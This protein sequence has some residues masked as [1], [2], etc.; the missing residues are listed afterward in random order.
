MFTYS[1]FLL[2]IWFNSSIYCKEVGVK[3][4]TM[5]MDLFVSSFS[6]GRWCFGYSEA[7]LGLYTFRTIKS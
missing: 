3:D 5:V 6:F 2:I 7:Q 4:V 1:V